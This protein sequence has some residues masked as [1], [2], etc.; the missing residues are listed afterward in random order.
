MPVDVK[1]DVS[2]MLDAL[3]GKVD[4]TEP[5]STDA[6][7][8]EP[9]PEDDVRTEAP[10][11]DEPEPEGEDDLADE[12]E[13]D[14]P[15]TDAPD[16]ADDRLS[17]IMRENAE[18]KQ[19]IAD[20]G[21]G[22]EVHTEA[23]TTDLPISEEDFVGGLDLDDLTSDPTELNKVL[24]TI[25]KKAVET[26]RGEYKEYGTKTLQQIPSMVNETISTKQALQELSKNF[27]EQNKDLKPWSKTVGVVF[28]ELIVENS[29]KPYAEVLDLV[30]KETRE[31][32]GLKKSQH[33]NKD[34][35]GDSDKPPPLHRKKGQRV[36]PKP[37]ERKGISSEIDEMNEA[38]NR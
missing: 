12:P 15:V 7:E 13:T 28:D 4:Q 31:R 26:V 21:K 22:K 36:R 19:K 32:I 11:T 30:A 29:D 3:E 8:L 14:A 18:L 5:P 6:P 33:V 10:T 9:E 27:Y 25:Y 1:D 17:K 37:S 34:D 24:N 35:N 20:L 2:A 23:P 38:L 16:D